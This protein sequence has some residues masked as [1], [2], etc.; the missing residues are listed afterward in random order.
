MYAL[1]SFITIY[2]SQYPQIAIFSESWL[3]LVR[4]LQNG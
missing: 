4:T 1:I 3:T 2:F